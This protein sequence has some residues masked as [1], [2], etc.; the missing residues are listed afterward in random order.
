MEDV[1]FNFED[2]KLY[3]KALDFTDYAYDLAAKFPSLENYGLRSQ[4]TRAA[5]SIA[6]NSSEGSGDTDSQFNR[7]LEMVSDSIRECV[8]CTTI[9]F[10]RNYISKEEN[11]KARNMLLEMLK[12]T[13]ALQRYLKQKPK[14]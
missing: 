12:M 4:L 7:Y 2:L 9:A 13:R 5:V 3:Q 6:L 14:K 10:R 1:H 11:I 8:A